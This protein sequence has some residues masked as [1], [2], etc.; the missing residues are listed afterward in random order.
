MNYKS[1]GP[2][3]ETKRIFG[4]LAIIFITAIFSFVLASF[5]NAFD[6]LIQW[7]DKEIWRPDELFIIFIILAFAFGIFSLVGIF[8][9]RRWIQLQRELTRRKQ[10]EAAL[11][12]AH[13]E[14][15]MRVA[16]RTSELSE[17][18]A[19]LKEEIAERKQA[20]AALRESEELFRQVISSISDF[21]YVNEL[22]D[23]AWVN[24]Y[25]SA[26]VEALTGYP[27]EKF[28]VDWSFWPATLIHPEDRVRVKD[29]AE[30]LAQGLSTEIEYRLVRADGQVIWV[31][32][33]ARVEC[34]PAAV[35]VVYGVVSDITERKRAE[36]EIRELNEALERRVIDRTRK[37]AALYEV[38]SVA[39]K[40]LNL[41]LTLKI[42]L[43]RLL[44]ALRSP[45]GAIH[46]LDDDDESLYPETQH[47]IPLNIRAYLDPNPDNHGLAG[48]V[49]E[50]NKPVVLTDLENQPDLPETLRNS[51]FQT[52]VGV[53]IR[54]REQA[55]GVLSVLERKAQQFDEGGV[56]L[57]TSIADQL[58]IAIENARLQKQAQQAAVMKE[59]ARLARDLHDSVT[60]SLYSLTLFAEA[61]S[62]LIEAGEI[63]SV[64]HNFVRIGETALQALKEMR[65]LV[66]ELRP[67]A[68]ERGGL[69][70]ALQQ[71][72]NAVEGRANV[73]VRLAVDDLIQL[74]ARLEEGLYRIAQEALNNT[75]K[76]AAATSVTVYLRGQDDWVE[77]EVVDNG[78]G[79]D[80]EAAET[81]GMGLISMRERA[82]KMG[83]KLAI[84]SK[85][86]EGTRIKAR[87]RRGS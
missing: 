65:L 46:L 70:D 5:L 84:Q 21:I 87:V 37:L 63:E 8:S 18:N 28:S 58:G 72:L 77:L 36:A 20:E 31:R 14:L 52:Y 74:P 78:A 83:G 15:E 41:K 13:D 25:L 62:D 69:I 40:S 60:Q 67:L 2:R 29:Q 3:P 42:S 44:L 24:R 73:K 80:P 53:P 4:D 10:A 50:Q 35:Y 30:Q 85:P 45:A 7:F 47:G 68:L 82:E 75:L 16:E 48:S 38:T 12:K 9:L 23:G 33:S 11:Q 76:H 27:Q 64:R 43:E 6:L 61:G 26:H 1:I 79:F 39:N 54:A 86:G 22:Q 71:R 17:A 56:A 32:D 81:G 59:R 19:R 51:G 66:H 49:I 34:E 57:L 55:L